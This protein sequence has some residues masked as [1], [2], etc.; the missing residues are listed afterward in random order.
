MTNRMD[1]GFEGLR[2]EFKAG[3]EGLRA[4]FKSDF[5]GLKS[6]FGHL[7]ADFGQLKSELHRVALLVKEQNARNRYVMDGYA[8]IYDLLVN[9]SSD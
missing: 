9:R 3:L 1:A 4:E 2:T 5:G 8:Q 6:Q 7:K